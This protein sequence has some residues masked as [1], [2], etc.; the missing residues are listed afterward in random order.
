LLTSALLLLVSTASPAVPALRVTALLDRD[1][2]R[3][4]DRA[5]AGNETRPVR[6][7]RSVVAPLVRSYTG[8]APPDRI[9]ELPVDR[10]PGDSPPGRF[11]LR[12]FVHV[13]DKVRLDDSEVVAPPPTVRVTFEPGEEGA[14]YGC[15]V[16][17]EPPPRPVA[18]VET[19]A[20]VD[21]PRG[22]ELRF[23]LTLVSDRCARHPATDV[24]MD[25][26]AGH[27]ARALFR[28]RLTAATACGRW[29]DVDVPVA[30]VDGSA[31]AFRL[32]VRA[33][34]P[35]DRDRALRV[36]WSD[37]LL[38]AERPERAAPPNVVV[39]S[40]DTLGARHVSTYGCRHP[41][42]LR[43]DQIGADGAVFTDTIC[44]YPT[45][46]GSHATLMTG[47]LPAVHGVRR[48]TDGSPLDVPM[49]AE[50]FRHAG[51]VTVAVTED[52]ALPGELFARG[53]HRYWENSAGFAKT[54]GMARETFGQA[55]AWLGARPV[56]PFFLFL[57][58]YQV[59]WPYDPTPRDLRAVRDGRGGD[60]ADPAWPYEGE[61]RFT[62]H[63][64][65]R[66]VSRLRRLG[67]LD[68]TIVVIT[69]DHGEA[70]GEH[71]TWQHGDMVYDEV[72]RVP[73][74]VRGPGVPAGVRPGAP[75][76]LVD[77]AP[78]VLE[79]AGL[80]VPTT[81]QGR[82]LVPLLRGRTLPPRPR[83]AELH[84]YVVPVRYEPNLRAVWLDG[85]KAIYDV[86][87]DRW[88]VF[89]IV[90]DP[91][92]QHDIAATASDTIATARSAVTAYEAMQRSAP[93]APVEPTPEMRERLKALGYVH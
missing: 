79:L 81:M 86:D 10:P 49:L 89:D 63:L 9:V 38:V 21:V 56:E 40:L 83:V 75:V 5:S 16:M 27:R 7:L 93:A 78:T 88:Q 82:S 74:V 55:Y 15:V 19:L 44:H 91:G 14:T 85:R 4:V 45:T 87:H 31:V 23:G 48:V 12:V 84:G 18:L 53:F 54:P 64:V 39:I 28:T 51:Y 3:A 69:S 65:G 17:V 50:I 90:A 35:A 47:V 52:N 33:A 57:H 58:T 67:V 1:P 66:F 60:G 61:I 37:P 42:T 24:R 59:H 62:D 26:V 71:G 43:I 29:L 32:R 41:T 22:A 80:E 73:L 36:V 8:T 72:M 11:G 6:F 92:E 30:G 25:A 34:D 68:R 70:F 46:P 13:G 77:V 2:A 76:G 20:P